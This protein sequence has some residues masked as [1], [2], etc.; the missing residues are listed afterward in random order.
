MKPTAKFH[1]EKDRA[2]GVTTPPGDPPTLKCIIANLK[3]QYCEKFHILDNLNK[4]WYN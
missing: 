2:T 3:C 1:I 4:I